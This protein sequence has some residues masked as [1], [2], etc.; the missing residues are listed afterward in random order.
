V[1]QHE[2][3]HDQQTNA[4]LRLAAAARLAR[5]GRT[6]LHRAAAAGRVLYAIV[7]GQRYFWSADVLAWSESRRDSKRAEVNM[8]RANDKTGGAA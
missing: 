2:S 3:P 7:D 1:P 8:R 4:W 5:V 6:T